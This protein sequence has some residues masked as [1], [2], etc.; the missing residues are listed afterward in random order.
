M[1]ILEN[2]IQNI[3]WNKIYY[4]TTSWDKSKPIVIFIHW[5]FGS[6]LIFKN[7]IIFLNLLNI[8]CLSIDLR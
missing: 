3:E 6:W 8:E 7:I 5:L 2:C 1:S 4:Y